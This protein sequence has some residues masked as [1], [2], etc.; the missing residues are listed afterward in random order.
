M[1]EPKALLDRLNF[2]NL[3]NAAKARL[4]GL[5]PVLMKR[6]PGALQKFYE[7]L[8]G[9]AHLRRLFKDDA[10]VS[11]AKARQGSHWDMISD[12]QFDE[13]YLAAVT[14]VGE[15]HARIGLE[16]RWYI[17]GY[18]M[19]LE[20]LV[21]A[22]LEARWPARKWFGR[23]PDS[24]STAEELA[25]LVKAT[26]LDMDLAISV[27][28]EASERGRLAAEA[29]S[30]AASEAVMRALAEAL[31]GLAAADLT[32]RISDNLPA[33][34]AQ[35]RTDFNGAIERL[36]GAFGGI[37]NNVGIINSGVAEITSASDDLARRTET[38][39]SS[40]EETNAAL[41]EITKSVKLASGGVTKANVAVRAAN[42]A[43]KHTSSVVGEAVAA[44][45]KIETSSREIGQI[46][47]LIDEIAFQTN[48]LALNAGVEAARAGDAGR[49]FAVVASEVRA[50][51][52]RSAEAAKAI[53]GL[54]SVSSEQVV[55]GVTLVRETGTALES[56]VGNVGEIDGLMGEIA[57]SA[58]KQAVALHEINS[59]MGQMSQSIHQTAAMV[60]ESTAAAHSLKAETAEL[61]GAVGVFKIKAGGR[62]AGKRALEKV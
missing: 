9:E 37:Q 7:K 46:I 11:S 22:V 58:E 39:A 28:L 55:Q 41:G 12:G 24:Q 14:K 34:F 51:A 59:A 10:A 29:K 19:I 16:P 48:L 17:G 2:I 4:L 45:N 56:I 8:Q 38:Q 52:Q 25:A 40:L 27:Y 57:A 49:G 44:M 33:E 5:K 62:V 53:K 18:A 20:N 23:Q 36:A 43:A 30:K 3:D 31:A 21:A 42:E 47:G 26:F 54:I 60:E 35:L 61:Q 50:L 15:I 32:T 13:R 1:S 6:L